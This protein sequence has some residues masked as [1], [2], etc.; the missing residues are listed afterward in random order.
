MT[1][2]LEELLPIL[3]QLS[4]DR[5]TRISLT[6]LAE[7]AGRS[8]SH[9]QRTFARVIGESPKQFARRLQLECAAVL[10]LTTTQTVLDV[11]LSCGFDSHEGFTRAFATQF[12]RAPRAFRADGVAGDLA[13]RLRHAELVTHVGPCL[14]LF[15]TPLA[16]NPEERTMSYD[17]TQQSIA[18]TTVLFKRTRIEHAKI[19]EALGQILPAVYGHALANGIT[20]VGP[21]FCRYVQWGP[22]MA[23]IEAGMPVAAGTLGTP[24]IEHAVWPACTAAV[25]IH[26]G[27]YDGLGEAHAALELYL[28]ENGLTA[29][30]PLREIYVTDPGEV[31][32]PAQWKTQVVWPL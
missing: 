26:T 2:A 10:L 17:I 21:P 28:H 31:P 7:Q 14:R 11:A 30:A 8:P 27:P 13:Q 9:F 32:D 15:H 20:M 25:T 12:G 5:S 16:D 3:A 6:E 4:R 19:A 24:D 1:T 29:S 18:E 22:A 23:T